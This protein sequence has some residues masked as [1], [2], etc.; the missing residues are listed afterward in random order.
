MSIILIWPMNTNLIKSN[1]FERFV[2]MFSIKKWQNTGSV[3]NHYS[4]PN[5]SLP[6]SCICGKTCKNEFKLNAWWRR[7]RG[8]PNFWKK[9]SKNLSK[10]VQTNVFRYRKRTRHVHNSKSL[11]TEKKK[12]LPHLNSTWNPKC[13]VQGLFRIF[14]QV[15]S[16]FQLKVLLKHHDKLHCFLYIVL[17]CIKW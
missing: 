15:I 5:Q 6:Q 7:R 16:K 1:I 12:A 13:L 3:L 9:E 11:C 17:V 4:A 14:I 8:S 2:I 10:C